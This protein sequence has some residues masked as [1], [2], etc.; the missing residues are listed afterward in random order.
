MFK[1][2]DGRGWGV[3]SWDAIPAGSFVASFLGKVF[4]CAVFFVGRGRCENAHKHKNTA[5]TPPPSPRAPNIPKPKQ[6]HQHAHKHNTNHNSIEK[7]GDGAYAD[8]TYHF[9]CGRRPDMSDDHALL[10]EP[11]AIEHEC[12]SFVVCCLCCCCG[13]V[14]PGGCVS[15]AWG[16]G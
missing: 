12:V 7:A 13:W 16:T 6:Q 3:R 4:R 11:R 10:P 15:G 14:S 9:E 8:D 2:P 1:T 5:D